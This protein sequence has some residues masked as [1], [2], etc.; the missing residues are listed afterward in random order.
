MKKTILIMAVCTLMTTSISSSFGQSP[1]KDSVQTNV[2][3]KEA[4]K[5]ASSEFQKFKKESELSIKNIDNII[6]DLK[7]VFYQ[8]KIKD[9][10]AFQDNLNL[11]EEKNDNLGKKLTDY[12]ESD[13]STLTSFK[14][15]IK[16]GLVDIAK[17]LKT[18]AADNK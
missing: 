1:V 2:Q 9:K 17:T 4:P 15:E 16:Q 6:G 7:V 10:I 13:Q 11:L 12:K 8:N 18:F 5:D 14:V 3:I